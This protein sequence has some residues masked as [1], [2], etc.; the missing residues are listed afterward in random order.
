MT[1]YYKDKSLPNRFKQ[2]RLEKHLSQPALSLAL[3][4]TGKKATIYAYENNTRIPNVPTLIKMKKLFSVSLDYLLCLDDY[5]D[6]N[7]FVIQNLGLDLETISMLSNLS[8][9]EHMTNEIIHYIKN[10]L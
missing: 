3:G 6:H 9:D 4:F 1:F 2:C 7:D 8:Q 5:K 10:N